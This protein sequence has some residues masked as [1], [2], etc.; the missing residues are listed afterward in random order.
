MAQSRY[1][2]SNVL[3]NRS[4]CIKGLGQLENHQRLGVVSLSIPIKRQDF[5]ETPLYNSGV[6]R[7]ES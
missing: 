7:F 6:T 4:I 3:P 2:I 5:C 1:H